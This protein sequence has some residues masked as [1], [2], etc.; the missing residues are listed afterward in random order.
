MFIAAL[1]HL[2]F[3]LANLHNKFSKCIRCIAS[4]FQLLKAPFEMFYKK[5][6][7]VYSCHPIRFFAN[8]FY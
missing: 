5:S 7:L 3:Y 2:I 6:T 4:N 1:N 8:G